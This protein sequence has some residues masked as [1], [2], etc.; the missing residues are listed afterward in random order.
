MLLR[1]QSMYTGK[2]CF[3]GRSPCRPANFF[4]AS[5]T[6]NQNGTVD[7][8][9]AASPSLAP[10]AVCRSVNTSQ[11]LPLV[12]EKVQLVPPSPCTTGYQEWFTP[13]TT[14][15]PTAQHRTRFLL[16]YIRH[17]NMDKEC[18]ISDI[19]PYSI[20]MWWLESA[21]PYRFRW[22]I[23]SDGYITFHATS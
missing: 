16:G 9:F 17:Q 3:S 11:R 13:H 23:N 12:D 20:Y 4:G 18:S 15:E 19:A 6:N 5:D 22:K 10:L 7:E 1:S 8:L 2:L 14:H 21:K